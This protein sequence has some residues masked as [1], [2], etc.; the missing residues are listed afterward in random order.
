MG[1]YLYDSP[2]NGFVFS[3]IPF[4]KKTDRSQNKYS[5]SHIFFEKHLYLCVIY[6]K[7]LNMKTLRKIKLQGELDVL[8]DEELKW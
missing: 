7:V 2:K 6:K 1:I 8:N 3:N 4:K 5:L